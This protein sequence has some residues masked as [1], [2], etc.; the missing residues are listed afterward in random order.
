MDKIKTII[1]GILTFISSWLGVLAIPVKLLAIS[2]IIDYITGI[3]ATKYRGNKI[4]SYVSFKGII[5]K[6]SMWLLVYVGLLVDNLILYSEDYMG[7]NIHFNFVVAS[8]VAIW[9][10]I[11]E[12]ISILENI[13]DTGVEIPSFLLP[14]VKNLR[15]QIDKETGSNDEK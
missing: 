7:I 9:L 14:F 11:N 13:R 6:V 1:I 4:S 3:F 12:I 5:K 8:L 10:L 2:N 15:S